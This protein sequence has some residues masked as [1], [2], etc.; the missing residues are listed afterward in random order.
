MHTPD[1]VRQR[2]WTLAC[3]RIPNV[4][5]MHQLPIGDMLVS[6]SPHFGDL[7][8]SVSIHVDE[9]VIDEIAACS[10]PVRQTQMYS[11]IDAWVL[12]RIPALLEAKIGCRR[13]LINMGH[14]ALLA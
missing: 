13:F 3:Q 9:Q 10:D 7:D 5:A 2:V 6:C 14:E 4:H 11:S 1:Q 12:L 8:A